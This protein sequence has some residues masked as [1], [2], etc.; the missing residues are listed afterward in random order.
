MVASSIGRG[1]VA[2]ASFAGTLTDMGLPG[3][4]RD[5][6]NG[7]LSFCWDLLVTGSSRRVE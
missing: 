1:S 4:Y 3:F 7:R 2:A 6:I 5:R